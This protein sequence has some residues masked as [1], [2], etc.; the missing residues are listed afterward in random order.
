M[1]KKPVV[2]NYYL[3]RL[4]PEDIDYVNNNFSVYK[5]MSCTMGTPFFVLNYPPAK[6]LNKANKL[7]LCMRASGKEYIARPVPGRVGMR[8]LIEDPENSNLGKNIC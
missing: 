6:K 2:Y 1:S 7:P 8:Y 5:I 3:S 4:S